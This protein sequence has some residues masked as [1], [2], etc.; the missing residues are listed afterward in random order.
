[1]GVG[2]YTGKEGAKNLVGE[3]S[4]LS[5]S[6]SLTS[7]GQLVLQLLV[8]DRQSKNRKNRWEAQESWR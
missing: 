4:A 6:E 3:T 2:L 5:S 1:V 7:T 8:I